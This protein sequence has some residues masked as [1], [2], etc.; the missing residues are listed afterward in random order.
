MNRPGTG[1]EEVF[2]GRLVLVLTLLLVCGLFITLEVLMSGLHALLSQME[3][4]LV[5]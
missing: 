3:G 4:L 2:E 5:R 1:G